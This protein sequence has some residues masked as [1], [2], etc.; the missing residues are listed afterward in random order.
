MYTRRRTAGFT[1]LEMLAVITI[2]GIIASIVISR[3]SHHALDAKRK[4]CWQYKADL[5]SA[6]ESYR[7]ETGGLPANVGVLEGTY[8]PQVVPKCPIT[9]LD[10][11]IDVTTGRI[12]GHAH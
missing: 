8:Y 11:D 7:F 10:Y 4:S 2:I 12:M 6:I 9:Q 1:L 3:V 5:N